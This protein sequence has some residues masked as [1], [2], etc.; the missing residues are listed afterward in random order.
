MVASGST[1]LIPH[2][3]LPLRIRSTVCSR[4]THR[5][6]S[7]VSSNEALLLHQSVS[8]YAS[9]QSPSQYPKR[10]SI[11]RRICAGYS[12]N[13]RRTGRCGYPVQETI[14]TYA[15]LCG[16]GSAYS[17]FSAGISS[18]LINLGFDDVVAQINS[19]EDLMKLSHSAKDTTISE[20]PLT[21]NQTQITS[22]DR[23]R[24]RNN[25]RNNRGR[26]QNGGQYI[27]RC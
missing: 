23:G 26:G 10:Y 27:P 2:R 16:L 13:L 3:Y 8:N 1:S 17:T 15:L 7:M 9:A 25:G 18:N 19:Y 14:S 21:A 5:Q 4:K 12:M 22:S 24:G 20:F 6:R 11:Y